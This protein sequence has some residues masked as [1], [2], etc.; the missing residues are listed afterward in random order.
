MALAYLAVLLIYYLRSGTFFQFLLGIYAMAALPIVWFLGRT[1]EF[2]KNWMPLIILLLSYEALNGLTGTFAS[3][4]TLVSLYSY[5]RLLWGF[6]LTG[7]V[8]SLWNS[9]PLTIFFI[10]IYSLHFP[11]VIIA[12]VYFWYTNK[13]IYGKYASALLLTSYLALAT[14][15]I[16]PTAPPW[17]SG[18]AKDL[19]Q[20]TRGPTVLLSSTLGRLSSLIESDKFAAFP[21]LHTAY[22]TLFSYYTVKA[23]LSLGLISLPLL[24]GVL[25]STI[26]L[27]QH[28]VI[29]LI[30]GAAYALVVI[31]VVNKIPRFRGA[32][33]F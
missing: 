25:L 14:F 12:S 4:G 20:D 23:K 18:I 2:L 27:G 13:A 16:M 29:D 7:T 15:L 22:V 32:F 5:D 33:G 9:A 30:G 8:Q 6:N 11:L 19:M 31:L 26:Y 10:F 24:V 1:R 21:S 3:S 17:Y 28:Y